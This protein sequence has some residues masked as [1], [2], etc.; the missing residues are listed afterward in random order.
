[1]GRHLCSGRFRRQQWEDCVSCGREIF[2]PSVVKDSA[3]T[4]DHHMRSQ[5]VLSIVRCSDP[6]SAVALGLYNC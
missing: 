5:Q 3:S 4:C 1:M 6:T 2:V